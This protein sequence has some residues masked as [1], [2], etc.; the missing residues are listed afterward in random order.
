MFLGIY[1][2]IFYICNFIED[3][4][5][6]NFLFLQLA[7]V[8]PFRRFPA[9]WNGVRPRFYLDYFLFYTWSQSFLQ[10]DTVFFFSSSKGS[11]VVFKKNTDIHKVF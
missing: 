3:I 8:N 1:L 10:I 9:F 2:N 11:G 5:L 7:I 4:H 6:L